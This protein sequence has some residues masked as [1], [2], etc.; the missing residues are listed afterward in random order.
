M[1]PS[2]FLDHIDTSFDRKIRHPVFFLRIELPNAETHEEAGIDHRRRLPHKE[3][4]AA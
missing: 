2:Y 4:T 3:E 1:W